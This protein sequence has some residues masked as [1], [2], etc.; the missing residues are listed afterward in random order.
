MVIG[1][2]KETGEQILNLST[3]RTNEMGIIR[4]NKNGMVTLV[5]LCNTPCLK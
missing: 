2:V 4:Q 1:L 5:Y 3:T